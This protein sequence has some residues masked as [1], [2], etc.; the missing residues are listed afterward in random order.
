VL[1]W[2][3]EILD[4][5]QA[6]LAGR[7]GAAEQT[8]RAIEAGRLKFSRKFA[9]RLAAQTGFDVE[10]LMRNELGN[11]PPSPAAV[12]NAFLQAQ[13]G[14]GTRADFSP[15]GRVAEALPHALILR[16]AWLQ[17]LIADEL[18]PVGALHTGFCD[19]LQKM[20]AKLLWK[21]PNTKT[22]HRVFQRSRDTGDEEIAE[23]FKRA[24]EALKE[25]T[26]A[27]RSSTKKRR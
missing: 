17:G 9:T 19:A 26:A 6:E 10:R 11:P 20:N 14:D 7:I 3:R 12:R 18:G 15:G 5:T 1:R 22:R 8:I 27:A 4:L 23:Y 2:I 13:K 25:V 24:S 16:G 21:I